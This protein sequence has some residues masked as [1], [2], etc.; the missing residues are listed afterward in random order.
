MG[1]MVTALQKIDAIGGDY[2]VNFNYVDV[3]SDT[4]SDI[5]PVWFFGGGFRQRF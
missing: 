5:D 4:N 1:H 3:E 2:Y